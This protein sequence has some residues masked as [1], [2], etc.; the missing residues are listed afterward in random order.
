MPKP[1]AETGLVVSYDYLWQSDKDRGW[2]EGGEHR[3][4]VVVSGSPPG[5]VLICGV[6][7]S[8]PH[9]PAYGIELDDEHKSALSLVSDRQWIHCN[10]I[11]IISWDDPELRPNPYGGW[12]YGY[13]GSVVGKQM[14]DKVRAIKAAGGLPTIK[15]EL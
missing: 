10:E 11:N 5:S 13:L 2:Q 14:L 9:D 15:R 4:C 7:R 12:E 8:E 6:S 3:P 1:D